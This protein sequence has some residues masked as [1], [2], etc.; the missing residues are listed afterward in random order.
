MKSLKWLLSL[1]LTVGLLAGGGATAVAAPIS[2]D[3]LSFDTY[4]VWPFAGLLE[5]QQYVK[6]WLDVNDYPTV[7]REG[8]VLHRDFVSKEKALLATIDNLSGRGK[9][10]FVATFAAIIDQQ[11]GV[12]IQSSSP[13]SGGTWYTISEINTKVERIRFLLPYYARAA[14]I[15]AAKPLKF[16]EW[17]IDDGTDG[18]DN[19][20]YKNGVFSCAIAPDGG[21]VL[22]DG[23]IISLWGE[24]IKKAP[25]PNTPPV[26]QPKAFT[27]TYT[28]T[29]S[30]TA[31]VGKTLTAKV[32]TWS[33][34][35]SKLTYQ[36]LRSG[37]VIAGAT[38]ST[39]KLTAA[40]KGKKMTVKVTGT[41]S[42]YTTVSKTS[43]ATSTIKAGTLKKGSVKV[44]GTKKVG[45]T[46]AA[47]TSK[48][49]SGVT[50]YY[51][52][53][54]SGKKISGATNSSYQ[55]VKKDKGKKVKVK[56]T[57]KKAGYSTAS[58]SSKYTSKIK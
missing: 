22:D 25:D 47:K 39:Y 21:F 12:D 16:T 19:V 17:F 49:S 54:R 26:T 14:G 20:V 3:R 7:Y 44:S 56:V 27:K 48:W 57:A 13:C 32:K 24:V 28:P 6:D 9:E 10:E 2:P 23:A 37:S 1:V 53:Y 38:K 33:P 52:W 42:G 58:K 18:F 45:K 50:Y 5:D 30:G 15:T 35:P 36:W 55:L 31:K 29:V 8:Y 4:G 34:K 51:Q 11:L 43:K 40:D 46:L 41:K